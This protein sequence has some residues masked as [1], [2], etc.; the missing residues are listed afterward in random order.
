MLFSINIVTNFFPKMKKLARKKGLVHFRYIK[1]DK[2]RED[3]IS[4]IERNLKKTKNGRYGKYDDYIELRSELLE[5]W[6]PGGSAAVDSYG[7]TWFL[8]IDLDVDAILMESGYPVPDI[9]SID[10]VK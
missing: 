10:P 8:D 4:L 1:E 7:K 5:I 2:L 3:T 6:I 9:D